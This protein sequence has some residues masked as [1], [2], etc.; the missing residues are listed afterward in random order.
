ME[1]EPRNA[2]EY[3]IQGN[4]LSQEHKYEK[5]I[6]AYRKAIQIRLDFAEAY[7]YLGNL[8]QIKPDF[9]EPY[10]HV[11]FV[12]D[13]YALNEQRKY[14]E[15]I[16]A[17]RKAIQIEPGYAEAYFD[18]GNALYQQ[19]KYEEAIAAYRRAILLN[20]DRYDTVLYQLQIYEKF[21][22]RSQYADQL[23]YVFAVARDSR[24]QLQRYLIAREKPYPQISDD[25]YFLPELSQE[26]LLA[27][28]RS[29]ARI[30]AMNPGFHNG[31]GWVVKRENNTLWIVTNRHVVVDTD[32]QQTR[33]K[34]EVE[35]Y[36][37][38]PYICRPKYLATVQNV[39]SDEKLDLAV[40]KIADVKLQDIKP[41]ALQLGWIA[42]N[43]SV[44]VISHS[45]NEN[46][47][48][49]PT[50]EKVINYSD[51]DQ[52]FTISR[53]TVDEGD[54]GGPVINVQNQIVGMFTFIRNEGD[55]DPKIASTT[56]LKKILPAIEKVG[57]AYRID[58]ILNQLRKW[59]II[60]STQP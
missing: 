25:S 20:P 45:S 29:T 15:V 18:L 54:S 6:A 55:L 51:S 4:V 36:S 50:S 56:N 41:L 49:I 38:L 47:Q 21:N 7:Y 23:E 40:L 30:N 57:L 39:S 14:E 43:T 9:T 12:L 16:A 26:P 35:F 59:E 5:A 13:R 44:T 28:L 48:W 10:Y 58:A 32:T 42:H 24:E 11:G 34:I 3:F 22:T 33:N 1:V 31:A 60:D 46:E 37:Q 19:Q 52:K 2:G 17:Y 53:T 8:L 27:I